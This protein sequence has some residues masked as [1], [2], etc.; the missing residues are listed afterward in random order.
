[1]IDTKRLTEWAVSQGGISAEAAEKL[2]AYAALLVE[3]N[4]KMNLTAIT[5]PEEMLVKHFADSLTLLPLLPETPCRLIDVG[6]GAGFPGVPLKV[7][8]PALNITLLDSLNKRLVFLEAVC[9][10][11]GIETAR[12]HARAEEGGRQAALRER[13]DVATARAVASLPTLCE[14]CLPFVKVGGVF[15]AMKGPDGHKEA[16]N[17]APAME[18]LGGKLKEVRSV[19]LPPL[20]GESAGE[21]C[22]VVIE[23]VA[24]TPPRYPRQSA[25]IAK[26]PLG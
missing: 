23:K 19:T 3:W 5:D 9:A 12:V 11:L 2:D 24:P 1:M 17:A 16:Q 20:L 7:A 13:F 15:L 26:E 4:Q 8:R 21:R 6:T 22:V 14:Y 18:L 10:A 25:K